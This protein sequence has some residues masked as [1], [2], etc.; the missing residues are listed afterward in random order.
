M[1]LSDAMDAFVGEARAV[2]IETEVSRRGLRLKRSGGE[3]VGP[4]PVCGGVDRFGVNPRKGVFLCRHS[5]TAGD[6]IALVEYLDGCDFLRA[7]ETLTGRPPPKGEGRGPDP[8]EIARREAARRVA[9]AERERGEIDYRETERARMWQL[10]RETARIAEGG[11]VARY[12]AGRGLSVP[13]GAS[14]RQ[15]DAVPFFVQDGRKPRQVHIGPAMIAAVV[16][17]GGIFRGAHITWLDAARAVKAEIVDPETGEVMP[18]RKMRGSMGGNHIVLSRPAKPRRLILGEG[19]E[20][21]LAVRDSLHA[22]RGAAYDS[23]TLYWAGISLGNIGGRALESVAHPT[24]TRTDKRGAVRK[25]R[26]PGPE[27]DCVPKHA[28]LMPPD[29]ISEIILLGDGDSDRFTTQMHLERAAR[30]W[31]RPGR[32]IRLPFAPEGRD[33]NDLL[34]EA[35]E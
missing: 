33:F 19:N 23:E 13:V 21:T 11:I 20:T 1:S 22:C 9:D 16:D 32:R 27:P 2:P 5:G 18:A 17:A 28:A 8:A 31:R 26:V 14:L 29:D 34:M 25:L 15:H 6:V 4:C 24:L 35:A 30:R 12:L 7:C 3:L 10:W